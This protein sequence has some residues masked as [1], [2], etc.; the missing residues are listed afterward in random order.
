MARPYFALTS[1]LLASSVS[2]SAFIISVP[3]HAQSEDAAQTCQ[4]PITSVETSLAACT[5]AIDS[6]DR[7]GAVADFQQTV[8]LSPQ[9][10]EAVERLQELGVRM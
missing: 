1:S 4:Q 6:G 3:A 2:L 9:F 7:D 5:A 10:K 8:K